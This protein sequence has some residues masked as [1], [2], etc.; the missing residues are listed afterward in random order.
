MCRLY[1]TP[2]HEWAGL[3]HSALPPD[4]LHQLQ[5]SRIFS[6]G[7]MGRLRRRNSLYPRKS[8]PTLH[9]GEVWSA[10]RQSLRGTGLKKGFL[11][12]GDTAVHGLRGDACMRQWILR[13]SSPRGFVPQVLPEHVPVVLERVWILFTSR[14]VSCGK[15]GE[16]P[17]LE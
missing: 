16:S 4:A 6:A 12:A 1:S 11:T 13:R 10:R 3:I 14:K 15:V 5:L 9:D 2:M 8:F 7:Q 17:S